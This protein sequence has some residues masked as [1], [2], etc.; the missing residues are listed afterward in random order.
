MEQNK[1]V[2]LNVSLSPYSNR[3]ISVFKGYC[4]LKSKQEALNKFVEVFGKTIIPTKEKEVKNEVIEEI[5]NLSKD[6]EK[7]SVVVTFEELDKMM[8]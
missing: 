8:M 6:K 5:L 4:D 2:S 1:G 7:N 3:V